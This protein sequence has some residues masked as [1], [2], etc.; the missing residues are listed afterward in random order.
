ML[1]SNPSLV[2]ANNLDKAKPSY[3]CTEDF[4]SKLNVVSSFKD[5]VVFSP[6]VSF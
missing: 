3:Y 6:F 4:Q 1:L 5:V 2:V